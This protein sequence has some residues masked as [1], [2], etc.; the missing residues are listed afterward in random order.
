[1]TTRRASVNNAAAS[2][3][4]T[5]LIGPAAPAEAAEPVAAR[6]VSSVMV[7][8]PLVTACYACSG[9]ACQCCARASAESSHWTIGLTA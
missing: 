9:G 1:M 8:D 4:D 5:F 3:G 2:S 7:P 6:V